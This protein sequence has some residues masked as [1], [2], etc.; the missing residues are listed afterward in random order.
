MCMCS[1][2]E[3]MWVPQQMSVW[4]DA[5]N[6]DQIPFATTNS[7]PRELNI[8]YSIS[9]IAFRDGKL[10]DENLIFNT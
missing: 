3:V 8:R 1:G 4:M 6:L 9:R 7:F 2:E 5:D 10:F